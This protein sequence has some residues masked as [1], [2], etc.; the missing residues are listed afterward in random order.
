MEELCRLFSKLYI[1]RPS[2]QKSPRLYSTN[3]NRGCVYFIKL[4]DYEN[5]YKYGCTRDIKK[6]LKVHRRNKLFGR[7]LVVDVVDC[8]VFHMQVEEHVKN[9]ASRNGTL[10]QLGS[11]VEIIK[12]NN[13]NKY[14]NAAKRKANSYSGYT[15]IIDNKIEYL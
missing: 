1:S 14:I 6:R 9:I 5:L 12:T 15:C 13:I 10:T 8:D 4:T 2:K 11:H 7:Q 3:A